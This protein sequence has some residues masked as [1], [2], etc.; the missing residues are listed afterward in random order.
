MTKHAHP[1][2]TL[3]LSF[4]SLVLCA[5]MLV[6]VT[7]A[8]FSDGVTSSNNRIVAGTLD[9]D[10]YYGN[11]DD[12]NSIQDVDT[13]FNDVT[14]WEPGAVAWENLT[15]VNLGS[16][17]L[18]YKLE[19]NFS[20][21]NYINENGA[22]LSQILRVAIV[23]GG[24]T[25]TT[26]EAV[27][28]QAGLGITL[29]DFAKG[30]YLN[31]KDTAGD[32]ATYG[33]VIYWPAY[34]DHNDW[35]LNNGKT[36]SDGE[37]LH[38]DLGINLTAWQKNAEVDSFGPDYDAGLGET[39]VSSYEE[40]K[41]ALAEGGK[42]VLESNVTVDATSNDEIA[43]VPEGVSV[44]LDLNGYTLATPDGVTGVYA[45][46]NRGTLTLLDSVSGGSV[47]ARGIYN[48]YDAAGNY[49]TDA[50][51]TVENGTYNAIGNGGGAAIFNY[52]T[53][54]V[55]GGLFTSLSSY[56]LNNRGTMT[57]KNAAVDGGIYCENG[58]LEI[59]DTDVRNTRTGAHA[60]YVSNSEVTINSGS[61][62]NE[63]ANN[64]TVIANGTSLVTIKDGEFSIG[65]SSYLLDGTKFVIEGGTFRGGLRGT[66]MEIS[67]G[68]FDNSNGSGYNLTD[69]T[70]TGGTFIDTNPAGLDASLQG[71]GS[72]YIAISYT[73]TPDAATFATEIE[74]ITCYVVSKR[75]T[76]VV[77]AA[78]D[79]VYA[80]ANENYT[81]KTVANNALASILA[82]LQNNEFN[83]VYL[84]P[85]TYNCASTLYVYSSMEIIGLGDKE[86][87]KVVKG[88]ASQS[89]RHLFNCSGTKEDYIEV[90]IRNL[91]LDA[92]AKTTAT[93]MNKQYN[94]AV[95]CIRKSKVKCYDLIITTG[96]NAFYG[97]SFYV[98][99]TNAVDGVTYPSY[100][101][102]E[103]CA[104]NSSYILSSSGTSYFYHYNLTHS[105]G[106][107]TYTTNSGRTKNVQMAPDDWTWD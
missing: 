9:V 4:L 66:N 32:R 50:K 31:P 77:L 7:F 100:M 13:L 12:E 78:P 19:V 34:G 47:T 26:R 70:I 45:L 89:N 14:L 72:E 63:N 29:A 95:Q 91:T 106:T 48:G 75:E 87:I 25:A 84:L 71:A 2:R 6:G 17:T 62:H 103:N 52:G 27:L 85:G 23:E 90:T 59:T 20:N 1:R 60:I 96:N 107:K 74:P 93:A 5:S 18:K 57:V 102:V 88:S 36:T 8:W 28:E 101:Y 30:G 97:Q 33:L 41:A 99:A 94:A 81:V 69:P 61:F 53:A 39:Y 68:S 82:G 54:N 15:V 3:I 35:N 51:L 42:V 16:L 44:T 55:N 43:I 80:P 76:T 22:R 21:E 86:D 105:N 79:T 46:N 73:K 64:A 67:G 92:S 58:T 11:P 40:F 65:T 10:V 37:P 24:I 38:V 104:I 56:A 98:N 83:S 49:V